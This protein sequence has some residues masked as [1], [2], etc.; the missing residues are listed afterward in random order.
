M[1]KQLSTLLIALVVLLASGCEQ[2]SNEYNLVPYP[3]QLKAQQGSFTINGSTKVSYQGSENSRFVAQAFADFIE[4]ASGLQLQIEPIENTELIKN[5]VCFVEDASLEGVEGSYQLVVTKDG[6]LVKSNNPVGLFYGFQTIRQL[7]PAKV[8]SKELVK[9]TDWTVPAVEITDAPNFSYRGLHLD[10]GRHF[11]PIDFIKKY[12]DLLALHKMNVFHW[13]LTED[14]GWRL[15]IKKY[16]KLAE[17]AAFRDETLVGHLGVGERQYDGKRYGGYYTQEEAREIVQYAAD[18]FI[19]VIPEIELPGHAQAALAA[20]PEFGCTGGPYEVAKE[21]GVFKEVY[22]AGNEEVFSFLEDVLVEVMDIFPSKYIHIGGDECPKARWE[23]CPKCKK[24]MQAEGCKDAHELQSYFIHRI[25]KF[26]NANGRDI[27]GWD[28]ILE[29]GLAPNATVMSWR[30]IKGGEEAAKQGHNVIMTPNTHFYLDYYQNNPQKEPL[31]I[32]GYLP[33]SK[34]YSYDPMA[35]DLTAEEAK[36]IIGVQ[37]NVWTEYMAESDYVEYMTYP[38][39]CAIAEVGWLDFS[40]RDY[41]AFARRLQS[42]FKRFDVMGVNYF[43]KVLMPSPSVEKV[44]FIDQA[45]LELFDN[46][47]GAKLYYTTDGSTPTDKSTLYQGA[48]TVKEECTIKAVAIDSRG[49]ASD[50]L[51]IP[52]QKLSF[53]EGIAKPGTEKG[54]ACKLATGKFEKCSEVDKAE[55]KS[56]VV[57]DVMIPSEA[58]HDNFGLSIEGV[59][60]IEQDGLYQF[61]L[62]SDDGSQLYLNDRLVIDND[63]FH[64]MIYKK[65]SLAL[66]KGAYPVKVLFFE[67]GGGEGLKLEMINVGGDMMQFSEY[68]SH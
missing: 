23:E 10:V 29:G 38:R 68:L 61:T 11:F 1:M 33:L 41:E 57:T 49:R 2:K 25:E 39:A 60:S 44:E 32:G 63:G 65:A 5:A 43:D 16:P 26:L 15:E 64:G 12:I 45:M 66:K 13:H 46:A 47:I 9:N 48:I 34:V 7:M 52:A 14:Q 50:V 62:G 31:A 24:R 55:G 4:P 22:C 54:L 35:G 18:R 19:T 17:V 20:Y 30:G 40:K 58:P 37:G 3:Q 6:I 27:I 56:L 53:I 59:L 8:E 51:E 28:E 42:H 67:G 36:H 21:W